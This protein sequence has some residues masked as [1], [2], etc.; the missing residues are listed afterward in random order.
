[1]TLT[2]NEISQAGRIERLQEIERRLYENVRIEEK[3]GSNTELLAQV[4]GIEYVSASRISEVSMCQT[5]LGIVKIGVA[6]QLCLGRT[7]DGLS[8]A[9]IACWCIWSSEL[10]FHV[11]SMTAYEK[12]WNWIHHAG[13]SRPWRAERATG[14]S[15]QSGDWRDQGCQQDSSGLSLL[16]HCV[17]RQ[18]PPMAGCCLPSGHTQGLQ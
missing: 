12:S 9:T 6:S 2:A 5:T 8:W 7:P 11:T 16:K 18:E 1:M 17:K 15:H 14:W 13:T 4:Q 3:A 10:R